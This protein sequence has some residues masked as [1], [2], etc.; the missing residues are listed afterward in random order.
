MHKIKHLILAIAAVATL[1]A[2]TVM[3]VPG[4]ALQFAAPCKAS[5]LTFPAWY[6]GLNCDGDGQPKITKLNH[7][8]VIALNL[9][10]MLIG[11]A[12]YVAVGYVSW[13]GFKYMKSQGDP[14]KISEAKGAILNAVIGLGVALS[15][16]AIVRFVQG[17]IV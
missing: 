14:G 1:V 7:I 8:W 4:Q 11:A 12:A 3:A 17:M 15:A 6:D 5:I 13:G 9:V 2:P 16:V 10:E